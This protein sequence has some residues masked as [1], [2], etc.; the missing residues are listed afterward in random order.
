MKAYIQIQVPSA[1]QATKRGA[2][3]GPTGV[4]MSRRAPGRVPGPVGVD[5]WQPSASRALEETI[6]GGS[7]TLELDDKN[8]EWRVKPP[9]FAA[10]SYYLPSTRGKWA[11]RGDEITIRDAVDKKIYFSLRQANTM[12]GQA[13]Y[14]PTLTGRYELH[15]EWKRVPK[16]LPISGRPP[17]W[18]GLAVAN[19]GS[20]ASAVVI[21]GSSSFSFLMPSVAAGSFRGYSWSAAFVLL[22]GYLDRGDLVNNPGLDIDYELS[23]G[24]RWRDQAGPLNQIAAGRSEGLADFALKNAEMLRAL[25][26]AALEGTCVDYDEKHVIIGDLA[27]AGIRTGIYAYTG[28]CVQG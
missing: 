1:T 19:S 25:G 20:A 27:G 6:P 7:V 5:L 23:L 24:T 14:N 9:A 2:P 10:W 4:E 16:P 26:M 3:P 13:S 11:R 28:D 22:T 12:M 18:Y 8:R 21:S 17:I 15:A